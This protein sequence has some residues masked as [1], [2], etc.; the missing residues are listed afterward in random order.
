LTVFR[1]VIFGSLFCAGIL[2]Q[3]QSTMAQNTVA[4]TAI[5]KAPSTPVM[6]GQTWREALSYVYAYNPELEAA[7]AEL[8]S[9]DEAVPQALA[10][11]RPTVSGAAKFTSSK[12]EPDSFGSNSGESENVAMAISQPIYTGGQTIANTKAAERQIFAARALLKSTEQ[13]VLR[14]AMAAY[15]DVLRDGQVVE[16]NLSN[17]KVLERQLEAAQD[18]F[19]LGEL[20]RTDVAQAKARLSAAK[21]S[22]IDATGQLRISAA[23]YENI[24][25]SLPEN[26]VKP[27]KLPSIPDNK[28]SILSEADENNPDIIFAEF[29]GQGSKFLIASAKGTLLPSISMDGNMSRT[30]N[31]LF[32]TASHQDDFSVSLTADVPLYS[33]GGNYSRIRQAKHVEN[34]MRINVFKAKRQV[35]QQAIAAWEGFLSADAEI[36]ARQLQVEASTLALEG[37]QEEANLGSRTVL[38]LLNAEQELLDARVG[39]VRVQRDKTIAIFDVLLSMGRLTAQGVDLNVDLYRPETHYNKTRAKWFGTD[40]D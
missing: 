7:R 26:L 34:Q 10:G 33:A 17:E 29:T 30:F 24:V 15:M 18:R 27:V 3:A 39:L 22:R 25:G 36:K 40:I 9:V 1:K 6:S 20:T 14:K 2:V 23:T 37:V 8:R 5:Q 21:A 31:P 16:L 13:D 35:R 28:Q 4:V 19:D 38:D 11:W 12:T 32:G